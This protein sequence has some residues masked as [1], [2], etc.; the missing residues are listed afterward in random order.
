MCVFREKVEDAWKN[1]EATINEAFKCRIQ[2]KP[3]Q[4]DRAFF[5]CRSDKEVNITEI[6]L[7]LEVQLQLD[8]KAGRRMKAVNVE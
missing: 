7:S 4:A 6:L 2:L 3:F 8:S 1:I 5:V